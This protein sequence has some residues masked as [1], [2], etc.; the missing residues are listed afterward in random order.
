MVTVSATGQNGYSGSV[1]VSLGTLPSGVTA[2][3]S[4]LTVSTGSSGSMTVAAAASAAAAQ[5]TI[6]VS[7]TS[8]TL[9][10]S[11]SL[12]LTV[13]AKPVPD[14]FHLV[15]GA[16]LGGFYDESRQLLFAT[17]L[18]LNELDVISGADD[19][20][21]ARIPVP[22]P[23]G[24][25]QMADGKTLVIGTAAQEIVT[26][27]EDTYAVTL[28][29]HSAPNATFSLFFPT[30]VALANGKV[31]M[32]GQEQGIDS[33]DIV[34]GGQYLLEWDSTTNTFS[35]IEP[36]SNDPIWETDRLARSADHK[37]AVFSA[38]Q[39]YLYSSDADTLTAAPLQTVDPPQNSFGVRGYAMNGDGS[40]IAVA[41]ATEVSFFD[42]E[43]DLLG[44]AQL[45]G[46]FQNSRT[47]VKFSADGSRLYLEYALPLAMVVV[48]ANSYA[49]LGTM[50]ATVNPEPDNLERLLTTDAEG[51]AYFATHEGLRLVNLSQPPIPVSQSTSAGPG[52]PECP[53][54]QV[55]A[56][57]N[58]AKASQELLEPIAGLSFYVGGQPAPVSNGS[59]VT[60]PA[61]SEAG[62]ADTE[63]IT[64]QG[65]TA[66]NKADVSYGVDPL[67][68]SA[69]LLP[70]GGKTG[71][72]LFGYGF[73]GSSGEVPA[74]TVGGAAS[75]QITMLQQS[76]VL[77]VAALAVP[78]GSAGQTVDVG[79]TSSVGSGTLTAAASYLPTPTILPAKGIL[80][81][82]FDT[83]RSVLYALKA[84][85]VDVLNPGN[86][87]WQAPLAFPA[88]F[89][90]TVQSMALAPDGSKLVVLATAAAQSTAEVLVMDLTGDSPATIATYSQADGV[91]GSIAVTNQNT[92][93][94]AGLPGL[95]LDLA[96]M[97]F[98]VE[99]NYAY[100]NIESGGVIRAS[101]DGSVVYSAILNESGGQVFS[102]N[103]ATGATKTEMFG[104]MFWTDLAVSPDG[105]Q[106]AAVEAP[107]GIGDLVGFFNADLQYINANV[108]PD[109]SPPDD[110][111]VLGV[112]YSP[113]GK[114]LVVP[115]GDS[116][117]LWDTAT[118]TLRARLMTPEELQVLVYPENGVAPLLALDAAGDTIYAVSK[119]GLSVIP[120]P[121]PMDEMTPV[122][123][124]ANRATRLG[125]ALRG[126]ATTR[127]AAI[128][129]ASRAGVSKR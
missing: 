62:P 6:S 36:T 25:D 87:T 58:Q 101:A 108:Y 41:S 126:T 117:E 13:T 40:K 89:T 28:H 39:F 114:V 24:I 66:V 49:T 37:W 19:T 111:G 44:T 5:E 78:A 109:F 38:D 122:A 110:S 54:L 35:Q 1:S 17:N 123:W 27:D 4:T 10:A 15:G 16:L 79:V 76:T 2:T 33:N 90:G 81:L 60:V 63:C 55:V 12:G 82:T 84:T 75:A 72:Y 129:G 45:P 51:H 113:G 91:N 116:I 70:P 86:L 59:T 85:E 69:S 26:V 107:P 8:G 119:S 31:F 47:V 88:A 46:A 52:V 96:T 94:L 21:K 104:Y 7:G 121:G 30:V 103:P 56:P 42:R 64:S 29:P 93:L 53:P 128:K 68:M 118:G 3:P 100:S 50:S 127:M 20:V 43:F 97:T 71:A 80:Q 9:T 99:D 124:P 32:I 61:S 98:T 65:D 73:S 95:T 11:A 92:V 102:F 18:G 83:H 34:D 14:P 22:Q 112:T 105:S 48:D 77:D 125:D 74:I 106:F 23:L 120:L 115:L 67:A 57:L